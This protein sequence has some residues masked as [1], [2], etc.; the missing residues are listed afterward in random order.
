MR[1]NQSF[2]PLAASG[3]TAFAL[4]A[5]VFVSS[6]FAEAADSTTKNGSAGCSCPNNSAQKTIKP[7]FADLKTPLDE[8]DE[9]AALE[10]VQFAL[11]EV[12]DGSS[13]VWHRSNGRLSGI[14]KPLTSFKD[15]Q[16]GI[17]RHVLVVLNSTDLTKKTE[18]VAC[19]L[20][21]GVWQLDG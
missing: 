8:N 9:I 13:Y 5:C 14:I 21:S 1:T 18:A 20:P 12:A 19:R 3:F 4:I 2:F 6:D 7:K 15:A 17:C 16:G 10:S 11:T